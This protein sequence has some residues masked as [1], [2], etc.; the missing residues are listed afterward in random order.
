MTYVLM[1]EEM[2]RPRLDAALDELRYE[3][4]ESPA[5]MAAQEAIMSMAPEG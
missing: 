5:A 2:G 1:A 4:G 3:W